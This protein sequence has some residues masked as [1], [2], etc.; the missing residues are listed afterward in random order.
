MGMER[1]FLT[2]HPESSRGP[3]CGERC[4]ELTAA[5]A[6]TLAWACLSPGEHGPRCFCPQRAEAGSLLPSV[7]P[8]CPRAGGDLFP[9]E[10][11]DVHRDASPRERCGHVRPGSWRLPPPPRLT[12]RPAAKFPMIAKQGAWCSPGPHG[13]RGGSPLTFRSWL[14]SEIWTL[15]SSWR[16]P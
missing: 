10:A 6:L 1:T 13:R 12:E 14:A 11:E 16:R 8:P 3:S 4:P 5:L 7:G 9:E 15:A 2:I